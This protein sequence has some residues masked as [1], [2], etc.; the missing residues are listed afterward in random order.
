M[1]VPRPPV[2][3]NRH[4]AQRFMLDSLSAVRE[5]L[6]A[7]AAEALARA[8]EW[9]LS[10]LSES[11]E[12]AERVRLWDYLGSGFRDRTQDVLRTRAVLCVLYYA[13]ED[14]PDVQQTLEYFVQSFVDGG[15]PVKALL[16]AGA[17][18]GAG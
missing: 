1:S 15:L 3:E 14:G 10:S 18:G 12:S 16:N 11:V 9:T 2:V 17:D 6:P 7:E 13:A 8:E 5:L 4:Q